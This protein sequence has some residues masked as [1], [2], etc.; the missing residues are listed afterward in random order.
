LQVQPGKITHKVVEP[1]CPTLVSP[2]FTAHP[3][4]L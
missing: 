1:F 4:Y 2:R 3:G